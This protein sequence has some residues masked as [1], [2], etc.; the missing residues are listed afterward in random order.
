MK[1]Y[2]VII[3]IT[4]FITVVIT[5]IACTPKPKIYKAYYYGDKHHVILIKER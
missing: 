1:K 2:L 5:M 3:L 4:L